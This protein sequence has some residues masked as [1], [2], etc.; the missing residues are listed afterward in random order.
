M[1]HKIKVV[2]HIDKDEDEILRLSLNN[3]KNFIDESL[4]ENYLYEIALVANYKAPLLFLKSSIN[5]DKLRFIKELNERGV[6]IYICERSM[7]ALNIRKE[8]LI[9]YCKTTPSGVFKIAELEK[10]GFAYIKP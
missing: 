8:D 1:N 9:D 7:K 2:F 6:K 4:L 3:I 10:E 5:E